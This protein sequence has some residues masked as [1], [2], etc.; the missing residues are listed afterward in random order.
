MINPS[1]LA[2]FTHPYTEPPP[3]PTQH[4]DLFSI[5]N[6]CGERCN[7]PCYGDHLYGPL[8]TAS[9]GGVNTYLMPADAQEGFDFVEGLKHMCRK[10]GLQEDAQV[11]WVGGDLTGIFPQEQAQRATQALKAFVSSTFFDAAGRI[12]NDRLMLSE[13]AG[14]EKE[15]EGW[16]AIRCVG[17]LLEQMP[18]LAG[19]FLPYGVVTGSDWFKSIGSVPHCGVK[20]LYVV[21]GNRPE[22]E[23]AWDSNAL[24]RNAL[25][26]EGGSRTLG[27]IFEIVASG[28]KVIGLHGLRGKRDAYLS[29]SKFVGDLCEYLKAHPLA[30]DDDVMVFWN[31]YT[32]KHLPFNPHA[33]DAHTKQKFID[34]AW[35]I[36]R[37]RGLI[38]TLQTHVSIYSH[39]DFLL[40]AH[41]KTV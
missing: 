38:H 15:G 39:E 36:F 35:K 8:R 37:E 1:S 14:P 18:E 16:C 25:I 32:A 4:E 28:G 19:N 40:S 6:S 3:T 20:H 7:N 29:A 30:T 41:S 11:W 23:D 9:V 24:A 26:L 10:M 17:K 5:L 13:Y 34:A 27:Y 22:T 31:E 2:T 12:R 21:H 33:S